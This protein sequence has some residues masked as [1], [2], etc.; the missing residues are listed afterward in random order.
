MKM[1]KTIAV[2]FVFIGFV[3]IIVVTGM[4][5]F[6][7]EGSKVFDS[8]IEVFKNSYHDTRRKKDGN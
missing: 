7:S 6:I 1:L 3:I 4:M 8:M 5:M 2:P